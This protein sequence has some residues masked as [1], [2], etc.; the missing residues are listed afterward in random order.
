MANQAVNRTVNHAANHA[1]NHVVN[2][3]ANLA[4]NLAVNH[5]ANLAEHRRRSAAFPTHTTTTTVSSTEARLPVEVGSR[6]RRGGEVEITTTKMTTALSAAWRSRRAVRHIG[7][8]WGRSRCGTTRDTLGRM[9]GGAV[10]GR[11]E[12]AEKD[13]ISASV[14]PLTKRSKISTASTETTTTEANGRASPD[15]WEQRVRWLRFGPGQCPP[16]CCLPWQGTR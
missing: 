9:D 5:A 3:A 6:A 16:P 10:T 4:A 15:C 13:A 2:H 8:R 7:G 12:G 1:V 14:L 11:G